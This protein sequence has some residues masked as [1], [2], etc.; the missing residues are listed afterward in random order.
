MLG[1]SLYGLPVVCFRNSGGA[2]ELVAN[3]AGCAVPYIK[4]DAFG[5]VV[6]ELADNVER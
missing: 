6:A 2:V 5:R 4:T 1:G 3:G